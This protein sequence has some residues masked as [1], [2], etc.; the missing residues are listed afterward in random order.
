VFFFIVTL[1]QAQHQI[2]IN[3]TLVPESKTIVVEQELIYKNNSDSILKEIYLNDWANSFS[4]KKTPLAK[5]FAENYQ[6]SFHFENNKNRGHTQIIKIN[7]SID[8]PLDWKRR[9]QLDIVKVELDKKLLPGEEYTLKLEYKIILPDDKFTRYGITKDGAIKIRYWYLAPAVFDQKWQIYS[10]KDLN[11]LYLTPSTFKIKFKTPAHY[12]L[13]TDLNVVSESIDDKIKVT[14]LE[15]DLRMNVKLQFLKVSN[16]QTL[17][18]DKFIISTNHS[19]KNVS[20]I[21]Q[22]LTIDRITH[23]LD[24]NLGEYPYDKMVISEID[25][26]RNPVYGLNLLPEFISPFPEGFEYDIEMLKIMTRTYL[27]NTLSVNPRK[28][29][30]LIGAFQVY[31]MIHY[32][33]T[34]Y[35]DMKLMGNLSNLWILKIFHASE[36]AFNEQYPFLYMN[37]AKYNLHQK[38]TVPKD[39]LL[40]FNKDIASDYHAGTGLVYLSAY[41]GKEPVLNSIKEFYV[42]NKLSAITALDFKKYLQRNTDKPIDWFF[43]DYIDNRSSIDFKLENLESSEDSL[44]IDIVHKKNTTLPVSIYGLNKQN[45]IFKKWLDPFDSLVTVKLP[46]KNIKRI[47]INFEGEIPEINQRNNYKKIKGLTNKPFQVRLFKDVEDPRYNQLFIMPAY[48]YNIY[49]GVTIGSM[50]Y[51]KAVLRKPFQYK[52]TPMW[53]LK[54]NT[55]VGSGSV[56]YKEMPEF[57]NLYFYRLGFSGSY[58]SYD[59]GLF[60]KR[61]SPFASVGF[62]NSNDLRNNKKHIINIRNVTVDRDKNPTVALESPNYSV[63]DINYT[64]SNP[65][66]INYYKAIVDYQ[67]SADFSKISTTLNY[68]KLFNNNRKIDV[69]LFTGIFIKNNTKLEDDYFSFALDRPTDYLFD[70][71]YYGR[72]DAAGLFSQQLIIAEGGFKSKLQPA[73]SNTWMTT[74]NVSTTIWRWIQAYGDLGWINNKNQGTEVVYDSGIRLSLVED[75]F[76]LFF[77][78]Y[79]NLGWEIAQPRYDQ[80]IRFIVTLDLK[81]L[82]GLFTRKWY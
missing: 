56:L 10:N 31:L 69:R 66:L 6:A 47:A 82:F 58:Y 61:F 14:Q 20:S 37:M 30:W 25:Y 35:P 38:N 15:G 44:K 78:V 73:F 43:E 60:Y 55:L 59:S 80:K 54:S 72:S 29:H 16:Y 48:N 3:A 79:S 75:Y 52:I 81:T 41:V 53:A 23:F 36:L 45:I 70:F 7:N 8:E 9:S 68:R 64:Y 33:E 57:G 63:F 49:D 11:D 77:P 1:V 2:N 12:Q 34:Y 51:N 76:E 32:I 62:R 22:A 4:S 71:N 39:S 19:H 26:E 50:F 65:N 17:E 67:V 40:K 24:Q 21:S 74:L 28:D 13:I 27:E 5:R 18:T 42:E 46:A